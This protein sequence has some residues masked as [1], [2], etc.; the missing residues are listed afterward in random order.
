[1]GFFLQSTYVFRHAI[2]REVVYN[3]ILAKRRKLLH[4]KIGKAIEELYAD[5]ISDHYGVLVEHFLAGESYEKAAKY[6][7]LASKKAEKTASLND[8]ILYAEKGIACLERLPANDE[9]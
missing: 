8:A 6:A 4:E 2:T 3:S 7:R 1:M 9:V 5:N